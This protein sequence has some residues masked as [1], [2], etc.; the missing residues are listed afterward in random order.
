MREEQQPLTPVNCTADF[1]ISFQMTN[2]GARHAC[3]VTIRAPSK[4]DASILFRDNWLTI[5][6]LALRNLLAREGK[7]IRLENP[8]FD[9]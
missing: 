1:K 8:P 2:A 5:Q 3:S 7:E 6:H 9:T 4:A